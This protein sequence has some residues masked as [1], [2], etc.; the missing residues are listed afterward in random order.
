ME[1]RNQDK[2]FHVEYSSLMVGAFRIC[3]S[4]AVE[5][6]QSGRVCYLKT[7]FAVYLSCNQSNLRLPC[8]RHLRGDWSW[9]RASSIRFL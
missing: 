6:I 3:Q 9:H 4:Y 8:L 1:Y 7:P 5:R 2:S